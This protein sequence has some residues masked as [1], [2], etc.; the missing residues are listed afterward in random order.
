MDDLVHLGGGSVLDNE[1]TLTVLGTG[2][3]G[4]TSLDY[5]GSAARLENEGTIH[6]EQHSQ[7]YVPI[8][9]SGDVIVDDTLD[10]GSQY[11]QT[12]GSTVLDGANLYGSIDIEGGVLKGNGTITGTVHNA[13]QLSPG[14]SPGAI[15]IAGNYTQTASG[16]Y[17]VEIGGPGAGTQYDQ[18][19]VSGAAALGGILNVSLVNG[20]MPHVGD[21]FTILH[22]TSG[23]AVTGTLAGLP[24]GAVLNG[25]FRINYVGG[26]VILTFVL[27]PPS[28]LSGIVWEDFNNNGQV[29]FGEKGIAGVTITLTGTDD[30]GHPVNL[31]LV[32]DADGAYVFLNLRPGNYVI[33]ETQPAG[34]GQGIDPV[35]TA[36]GALAAP[37]QFLV[38]LGPGIDG[39]NYNFGE[40][41]AA[42]GSVQH[43]QAATIGFWNNRNGQALIRAF[44]GGTGHR[45][46]DWL[47][48]TLPNTFGVYAGSNNLTGQSNAYV[49]ALFQQDFVLH[50]VKLNAQVL[51]T[52]LNVYATNATLDSTKV[53]AQYG[54]T[55][56]GDGLGAAGVNVGGDGDAFGV[57]N[58]TTMTVMD[59]LLATDSQAVN[60]VLYN[61]NS[62]KRSHANDVYSAINQ[63]GGP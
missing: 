12:A 13:G 57:A 62:T 25:L 47:A 18:V 52:A 63:A 49:A 28:S 27:P 55:V 34:Y 60:G 37:D 16:A 17:A 50:G 56:S 40:R 53:A 54:F 4:A 41:P 7:L 32:T 10:V 31:P 8:I 39:L 21:T 30:L 58:N 11:L 36:G 35:G 3:Y 23:S 44:D 61:G 38:T 6:T 9:N 19:T 46:A 15:T 24:D 29:D 48:A 1:G 5:D 33:T 20:Y 26:D 59:L 43:G 51:A 14:F 42:G 45:L 2:R 22:D